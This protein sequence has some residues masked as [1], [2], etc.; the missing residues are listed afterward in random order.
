MEMFKELGKGWEKKERKIEEMWPN[1]GVVSREKD[2]DDESEPS[3]EVLDVD[4]ETGS[5]VTIL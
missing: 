3:M 4:D 5:E 1:L 2:Y